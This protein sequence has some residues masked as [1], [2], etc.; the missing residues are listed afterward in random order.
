L[1]SGIVNLGG[2]ER[3]VLVR[4]DQTLGPRVKSGT[5]VVL[6]TG[7]QQRANPEPL[8]TMR[9]LESRITR[10]ELKLFNTE[11]RSETIAA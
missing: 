2:R 7:K 5:T 1:D 4:I 6:Q 3:A 10:Y 11:S 9:Q 8:S